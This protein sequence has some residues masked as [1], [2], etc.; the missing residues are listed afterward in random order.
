M[1]E[2]VEFLGYALKESVGMLF[3]L[4][5]GGYSY[6]N[7]LVSLAIVNIFVSAIVLNFTGRATDQIQKYSD[8]RSAS[9]R[10]ERA[11]AARSNAKSSPKG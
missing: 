4:N 7:M 9:V 6:G 2:F 1:T 5:I 8:D 3:K 11:R 10:R